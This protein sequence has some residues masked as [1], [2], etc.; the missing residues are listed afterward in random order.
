MKPIGTIGIIIAIVLSLVAVV[1]DFVRAQAPATTT[2]TST[3]PAADTTAKG[4]STDAGA[5]KKDDATTGTTTAK[6]ATTTDSPGVSGPTFP[7]IDPVV[8]QGPQFKV[9]PYP[10]GLANKDEL[11]PTGLVAGSFSAC[12][13]KQFGLRFQLLP[14]A[15]QAQVLK[16]YARFAVPE[17]NCLEDAKGPTPVDPFMYFLTLVVGSAALIW[18]FCFIRPVKG[19]L[20]EVIPLP[21]A[22]RHPAPTLDPA[23]V[24]TVIGAF[25]QHAATQHAAGTPYSQQEFKE[26]VQQTLAEIKPPAPD[27]DRPTRTYENKFSVSRLIALLGTY[28]II[29]TFGFASRYGFWALAFGDNSVFTS[30]TTTILI[31]GVGAFAP[32][33]VN[34]LTNAK[35]AAE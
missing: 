32:Y 8:F 10:G 23:I 28:V 17:A 31:G 21:A 19:F 25:T 27:R 16:E 12:V 3:T 2:T 30:I 35:P 29:V 15:T 20:E 1:P 34:R 4:T 14:A 6:P 5:P 13:E 9:E 11:T 7:A 33:V 24:A 26:A 22:E 18:V